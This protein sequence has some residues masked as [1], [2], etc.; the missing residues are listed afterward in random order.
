MGNRVRWSV[1]LL[2]LSCLTPLSTVIAAECTP[3]AAKLA[4]V[5]GKIEVQRSSTSPWLAVKLNDTFCTGDSIRSDQNSRAVII[6]ANQTLLRLDQ[7]SAI[8]LTQFKTDKPSIL[9]FIKGIG[10][11]I[12]R[13]P[14]SLKIETATVDAAIEGTEFVVAITDSETSIT[15]FEGHVLT[16]NSLGETSITNGETVIT[17]VNTAPVKTLLAKPRDAVQWALY[18]PPLIEADASASLSKASRLLYVGRV[19]EA[20]ALLADQNSGEALALKSIIASVNNLKDEAFKL[21]SDAI[22]LAPNSAATH[23]AMSYTWQAKL[24]LNQ[25]QQSAQ[26]AVKHQPHSAIAWARLAELQLSTGNLHGAQKSAD[27]ATQFNPELSRTQSILG[28]AH[29]VLIDID[30]AIA[31]FNKAIELDQ[32]D[33]LPR[34]GLGIAKIRNN[35]LSEGRRQ[36]EIAAS[37]DPNNAI[38]RSYLG[39]SYFEE[40]RSPLDADQFAMAKELDP[41]D[42]SP[43]FYDAIRKQSENNPAGALEDLNQSIKLNDNRAVY[44]SSLQLDQDEAARSVS[45]ARIYQDL[46]F[47]QLAINEATKSLANDP[48]NHSAHR[49]LADAYASRQRHETAQASELLQA[50]LLQPLSLTPL[51]PQFIESDLG[52]LNYANSFGNSSSDFTNLYTRNG[53]LAQVNLFSGNQNTKGDEFTFAGLYNNFAISAAQYAYRSDGLRLNNDASH[54]IYNLFM[55]VKVSGNLSLQA[56]YLDRSTDKGDLDIN[57]DAIID[58]SERTTIDTQISRFGFNYQAKTGHT[59]LGSFIHRKTE[60]INKSVSSITF[61]ITVIQTT[62]F[63]EHIK[64]RIS[65]I[66]HIYVSPELNITTGAIDTDVDSERIKNERTDLPPVIGT[67]FISST[68]LSKNHESFYS[69]MTLDT[70]E[71]MELALGLVYDNYEFT[72]STVERLNPKLGAKINL[73]DDTLLRIASFKLIKKPLVSGQTI[74]PTQFAGFNQFFEDLNGTKITQHNL[75]IEVNEFDSL[76]FGFDS[77]YRDMD[78]PRFVL[79]NVTFDE[80][81]ETNHHI[82]L[83]WSTNNI[84][85]L[86][87]EGFYENFENEEIVITNF[88]KKLT[89]KILPVNFI[90]NS[91]S[92]FSASIKPIYVNQNFVD[93]GDTAESDSFWVTD[94]LLEYK[95]AK[96]RGTFSVGAHN[97]FDKT[98]SFQK[99]NLTGEDN[100]PRFMPGV[101]F[102]FQLNLT[103]D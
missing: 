82:Y 59:L 35:H 50:Q 1:G 4:S 76:Y 85:S 33:P 42:P 14:R 54:D 68:D 83:N 7:Y 43:F 41:N 88:P 71:D 103:F 3:W 46:G 15:V 65:E 70:T 64:S 37:L 24:D 58:P 20:Q 73:T 2:L 57:F 39:K 29:L 30:E 102:I 101:S 9:E 94:L 17:K 55:Q 34:L 60:D 49:F 81:K 26:Q 98:F 95:L 13:V 99:L 80:I 25:A 66:Q 75:A 51:Q 86:S 61:P 48:A 23:I 52:T 92:G 11:F 12:S 90:F 8:K 84:F 40:K 87:L 44:R 53:S 77:F 72:D 69:Y 5:Q 21:A 96:R 93:S 6:L 32:V 31:V 18:F 67:P 27:Q 38:I 10:H 16:Q 19:K 89:T 45:L 78:A 56:E 79:G 47:E 91:S 22:K 97:V 28:Y 36:I 100:E 74:E 63:N 62:V